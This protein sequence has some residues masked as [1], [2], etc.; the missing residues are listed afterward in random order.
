MIRG[1]GNYLAR[2]EERIVQEL[3]VAF[4]FSLAFAFALSCPFSKAFDGSFLRA[5]VGAFLGAFL[6]AF[7]GEFS[8]S[9]VSARDVEWRAIG[10]LTLT[11]ALVSTWWGSDG[12]W[13][14]REFVI[15]MLGGVVREGLLSGSAAAFGSSGETRRA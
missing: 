12:V 7:G 10:E 8:F 2:V 1:C 5:L 3:F 9:F 13:K 11:F 6:G 15:V 14:R 4:S